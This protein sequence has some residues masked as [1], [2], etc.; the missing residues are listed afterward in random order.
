MML[1]KVHIVVH[2]LN[3]KQ[4]REQV[5][6]ARDA[7][8]DGVWMI[9]HAG[10][11]ARLLDLATTIRESFPDL[12]LGVNFLDLRVD[13]AM[14]VVGDQFDG[15]W[16]DNAHVH[17]DDD[18]QIAERARAARQGQRWSGLY[19]GGVAFKGQRLE[20]DVAAAAE[21][22]APF[23][24]VVTTSGMATG[25]SAPADKVRRM[26]EALGGRRPLALA[27]GITPENVEVYLPYVE[28]L[29]IATGVAR[30]F[31]EL[32]PRKIEKLVERVRAW[33]AR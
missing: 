3:A 14:G 31:H 21:R 30:S 27:S 23:V 1:P 2:V 5:A 28:Y 20:R 18:L 24:D 25:V 33:I 13:D 9:D 16:S 22:A 29:M 8:V 17:P 6:L 26:H 12:W 15:L 7:G 10:D 19:F 4:A 32:D 11:H